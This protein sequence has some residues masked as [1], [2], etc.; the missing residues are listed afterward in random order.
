MAWTKESGAIATISGITNWAGDWDVATAYEVGSGVY[1]EGSAYV[2]ILAH[3][4]ETPASD[5]DY[6]NLVAAKGEQ[7]DVGPEGPQGG[8]AANWLGTYN[9]A[10][11][12][13][14]DDAISYN[15]SSYVCILASTGNLP[16]NGTYWLLVAQKGDTG[17]TG[18]TGEAGETGA[19][20]ISASF[21]GDDLVF[22][23]DDDDTVS[24]L[25]AK[26]DLKGDTGET[27][28]TG[29][30][31]P[32]GPAGATGATGAAGATGPQGPQGP[33]GADGADGDD[34]AQ[35]P[36]GADGAQGPAGADGDDGVSFIWRGAY[37][38]GTAY[39]VN[40]AVSYNG[41]SYI[42][43]LS[44]TG[45]LPTNT[46]YWDLMALKGDTGASGE[47]TG[48]VVGP[49]T[50]T[51]S[52]IPQWD[53]ANSKI[54]K[55]G[56]PTSTFEPAKGTDDNYVT[57]AEKVVIGNTSGTNSGNETATTI[58]A[59]IGGAADA[60][61]N[62]TDF[63]ATSLTAAGILKK[64]TW[65]NVKAFLKTYFDTLY[66][67]IQPTTIELGH[68]S[69]TTISRSS[70]GVIAVEG[71]VIPSVSST[72]TLT[73]KTLTSPVLTTPTLGTPAS[74][75]LTNCS[76]LPVSGIAAST[77]TAIGVGSIN[78]GHASDTTIARVSAGLIS[79]EGVNVVLASSS[80]TLG[81]VTT[82]GNIELG[83]ASDTTISRSAA[84]V[85]AVEGVV[86]PSIS[87]TDTLT[88]K[89]ITQRVTTATDSATA[90][91]N[92]DN[93]DQYQLTAI[94][95]NTTIATTG[96]PTNG[97]KLM[98][99]LK[100]AGTGKTLTWNAV[101]RAIGVT[102]PTTTVAGKTHYIGAV[103][104]SAD[105]KWDVLAVGAEA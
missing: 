30:Q 63:V 26:V 92:I 48:D 31:G 53:G 59:L 99:R 4:G 91:I 74:G 65:T 86:V 15:G 20:I 72:N 85:I 79:V 6:W 22:V 88:N 7:G 105:S 96:T 94:A 81:T 19:S 42:C 93:C 46:T 95:N 37:A 102:L 70:A 67:A 90:T 103:Y 97:Q 89:R 49:A 100:D 24:L 51:D 57:D 18:T 68:A 17:E 75:T 35:G 80:P 34:G 5:S 101:F 98:I 87:S 55:N 66:L 52:Y 82:T 39:V 27:G 104:N 28:T 14:P 25:D 29:A 43:K 40:D 3:T 50:N 45:N 16:T 73:N 64:I 41:S 23:K 71:V 36:A 58:G 78:L 83:H 11:T 84:G 56:I 44:S 69:D 47:G 2:C 54:L 33:A 12:Y 32:Q 60:T 76:G 13:A 21:V 61:P 1:Y 9:P 10:T 38:G 8:S 62:D 77:S